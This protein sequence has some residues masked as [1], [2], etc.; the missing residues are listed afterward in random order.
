MYK[1]I[2]LN[3]A[4]S[5][6]IKTLKTNFAGKLITS[7]STELFFKIDDNK[8]V[9]IFNYGVVA[10]CNVEQD[11]IE[12]AISILGD[13]IKSEQDRLTE[14]IEIQFSDVKIPIYDE[15]I[16]SLPLKFNFDAIFRIVM[17]D[18]SQSVALD[19]YSGVAEK[20]LNQVKLFASELEKKGKISLSKKEMMKFIGKSLNTKDKIVDNFYIFDSPDITWDNAKIDKVHKLLVRTFD[21]NVRFKEIEYTFNIIDDNLQMFK[22]TYEHEHSATLEIVVIILI[23]IEILNSF[24]EKFD[25]F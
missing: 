14:S 7:T 15:D 1:L 12:S 2:A 19:Y 21:L 16:L 6:D 5:I 25:W 13:F 20:L 9:S 22:D 23:L 17:F 4:D 3:I 18:L 24:S 10:F 8:Y 11:E